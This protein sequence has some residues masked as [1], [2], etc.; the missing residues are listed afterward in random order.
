MKTRQLEDITAKEYWFEEFDFT[1]PVCGGTGE[2]PF[3]NDGDCRFCSERGGSYF[4]ILWNTLFEVPYLKPGLD[5]ARAKRIA[6]RLGWLLI[7]DPDDESLWLAAG[8]CGY[9]FTWQR[10]KVIIALCGQL[11]AEYADAV[12][13]GGYVFVSAHDARIIA[14][15]VIAANETVI[16]RA[17]CNQA[18]GQLLLDKLASPDYEHDY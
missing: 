2:N 6:W 12:S 5:F 11:P 15:Q 10:A 13:S 16:L 18:E 8:S 9:D 1:C 14:T 7:A 4:D 3:T 17:M